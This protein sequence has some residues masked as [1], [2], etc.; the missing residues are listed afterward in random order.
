[1][2]LLI[3]AP[4]MTNSWP[5]WNPNSAQVTPVIRAL[6]GDPPPTR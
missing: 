3:P 5:A 4:E 2:P 6:A 1:V